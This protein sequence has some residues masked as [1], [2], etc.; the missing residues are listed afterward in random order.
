MVFF[1]VSF[2]SCSSSLLSFWTLL[3]WRAASS[4]KPPSGNTTAFQQHSSKQIGPDASEQFRKP[5]MRG[6]GAVPC[7]SEN[8]I[9]LM[10]KGSRVDSQVGLYGGL[11]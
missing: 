2:V 10:G 5:G 4:C 11:C 3:Y 8:S 7:R 6:L 1:V 9:S